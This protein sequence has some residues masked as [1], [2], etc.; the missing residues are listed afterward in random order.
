M[1]D[2]ITTPYVD[3]EQALFERGEACTD[4]EHRLLQR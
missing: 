1:A 2:T 4:V 3:N